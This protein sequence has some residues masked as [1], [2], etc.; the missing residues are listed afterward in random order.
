[1]FSFVNAACQLSVRGE[2]RLFIV[3]AA[4]PERD[5][6]QATIAFA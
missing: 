5:E 4:H 1:V 6:G 3:A 2:W